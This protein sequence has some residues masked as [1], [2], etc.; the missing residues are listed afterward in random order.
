MASGKQRELPRD[1]ARGRDRFAAWRRART[2]KG[3]IPDPLWEMAVELAGTH[4]VHRTAQALKLRYYS[5]KKHVAAA[6]GPRENRP[7]FVEISPSFA[8]VAE[9]VI[10]LKDGAVSLRVHRKGYSTR[11][12][13]S[14]RCEPIILNL[15][16]FKSNWYRLNLEN[17]WVVDVVLSADM[18][19]TIL[20]SQASVVYHC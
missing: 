8:T 5:L 6:A 4:G 20:E 17:Q 10:E 11:N 15:P 19:P 18:C 7:E 9:C 16:D 14:H 13:G 2:G 12:S 1:L 3:R